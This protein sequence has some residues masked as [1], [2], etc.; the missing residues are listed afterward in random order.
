[1]DGIINN[2][3]IRIK[4]LGNGKIMIC[5]FCNCK[6]T[7]VKDSR[8]NDDGASIKRRRICGSCDQRF[9]TIE[10]YYPKEVLVV[11]RSGVKKLFDMDKIVR[12]IKMA[13]RKREISIPQME[14]IAHNILKSVENSPAREISTVQI[15]EKIMMALSE[16]DQVAYIR[17]ASVY[18]EFNS[19]KDFLKFVK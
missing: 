5:P 3:A 12:S 10:K 14:Q 16:I 17:F 8:E 19:A 4:K 7:S 18:H 11:K 15:G 13:S 2:T 1:M 9:T 6:D